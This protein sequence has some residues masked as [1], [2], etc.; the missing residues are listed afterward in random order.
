MRR[1]EPTIL[2]YQ[3]DRLDCHVLYLVSLIDAELQID[4][5]Q[6]A[7]CKIPIHSLV[8]EWIF[9]LLKRK[10]CRKDRVLS[11]LCQ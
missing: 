10:F 4:I 5:G 2:L 8:L 11:T 3:W 1:N 6:I 7:I 9:V